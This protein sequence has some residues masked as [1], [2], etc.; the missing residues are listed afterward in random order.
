MMRPPQILL[1]VFAAVILSLSVGCGSGDD[2]QGQSQNSDAH[3]SSQVDAGDTGGSEFAAFT[4][5][6]Q[7]LT[8]NGEFYVTYTPNPD[9]IPV[10][11]LFTLEFRVYASDEQENGIPGADLSIEAQMPTHDHGMTT[12]PSISEPSD[13]TY[14][15][16]GMKFHMPSDARD[17]WTMEL[18]VDDGENT[19]VARF[20]VVTD[21]D[22]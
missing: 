22:Q 14:R 10:S 9:P 21:A 20:M 12:E 1:H 5:D 17:P 4:P 16:E 13:G 3:A 7:T 6:R 8:E 18:T 2:N 19:D 15:I 11:E